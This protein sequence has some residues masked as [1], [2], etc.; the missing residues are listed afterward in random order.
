MLKLL[1]MLLRTS[2]SSLLTTLL[3]GLASGASSAALL[4]VINQAL[5]RP[6]EERLRLG[7]AFG[8]LAVLAMFTRAGSQMLLNGMH[9]NI[10]MDLR[11]R[12]ARQFLAISLRHLE[13]TG[14]HRLLSS[15]SSD[16][17]MVGVG[18]TALPEFFISITIVTGSLIYLAWISW[19]MLLVVLGFLAVGGLA[20]SQ[21]T[22][23]AVKLRQQVRQLENGLFKRFLSLMDGA[24]EL[25]LHRPRRI[26]FLERVFDPLVRDIR[27]KWVRAENLF[28]LASSGGMFVYMVIIGLLLFVVPLFSPVS[29]AALVSYT[30]VILYVQ[31]PLN[32]ILTTV[33]YVNRAVVALENLHK[34]GLTLTPENETPWALPPETP[35]RLRAF[36]QLELRGITHT[37]RRENE[38]GSFTL[39]PIDLTVKRGELL[40][41]VG[42]NGSGKTTL[43]KLLTGLYA[44]E[45]G[46]LLVD[47]TPIRNEE[48]EEYRQLFSAVFFDFHLFDQLLGLGSPEQ[49]DQA[50]HY[51][52][53]LLLDRKVQIQ[54]GSFSTTELSQGQRKRL[55]L[56]TASLEDRPFYIF[57]EWAADQDPSFK[58]VFYKEILPDLKRLGKTVLVISHDDR[59]FG[60]ADRLL[61]L[62]AGRLTPLEQPRLDQVGT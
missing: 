8:G 7:L 3:F 1:V 47:G 23:P 31:Q 15:M 12:L 18:M 19:K 21:A 38:D 55:A 37:Y 17:V 20:Y 52:S 62:E 2:R 40:F 50:R 6:E 58:E 34:L 16:T 48:R 11:R 14:S 26:E 22:S 33:A 39:G 5:A 35:A 4:S 45:A 46:E 42:G 60:L 59:Y 51:L 9:Q 27:G 44:P 30:L 10:V 57:D 36:Q 54:D 24:K 53:K 49:L 32:S 29:Q 28:A 56:L 41:L 61:H 43:A 13:Q 25:R